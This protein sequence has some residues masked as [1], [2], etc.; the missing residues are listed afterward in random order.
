MRTMRVIGV[1]ALFAALL[2]GTVL[3]F[4]AFDGRSHSVSDTLRPFIVTV[5]PVWVV[6][7]ACAR[8][9]RRLPGRREHS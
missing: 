2:V 4:A 9:M 7:L 5:A 3:V 8:V 1:V 6:V